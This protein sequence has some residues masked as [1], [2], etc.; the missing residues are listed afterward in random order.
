[1]NRHPPWQEV[2]PTPLLVASG[3]VFSQLNTLFCGFA[4]LAAQDQQEGPDVGREPD[5]EGGMAVVR[6]VGRLA[7]IPQIA[8]HDLRPTCARSCHLAGGGE[9]KQIQL[10]LGDVSVQT[11]ER[12]LGCKQK[13][14]HTLN[15]NLG[16]VDA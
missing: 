13:L 10:L 16:L 1:M 12:Y 3:C 5:S 2:D 6:G 14:R 7:G 4:L 11:T 15:D 8:P 9:L